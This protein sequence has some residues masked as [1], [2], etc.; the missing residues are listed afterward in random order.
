[1]KIIICSLFIF[2]Y[3]CQPNINEKTSNPNVLNEITVPTKESGEPNL[4]T[5]EKGEIYLS[6]IEYLNDSTDALLFSKLENGNWS[7]PKTITSATNLF[8][9]WADFPSIVSYKNNEHQFAAHWMQMRSKGTYDYDVYISQSNDNGISWQPPFI[10][11]RDSIAAEHGFVTMLPLSNDRIFATWLDGRNTKGDNPTEHSGH[12]HHGAMTLQAATFDIKGNIYEEVEL[13]DR[14]C[15]CC[16]TT[17]AITE[18][19]IIVSYRDRSEKEIRDI[20]IVRQLNGKWTAPSSVFEDNWKI[21]GCPVNGPSIKANGSN[22]A[23]AWFTMEGE[24]GVVKIAFSKDNGKSFQKP[25]RVDD[26]DPLGRVDLI[27]DSKDEIIVSWIEKTE[28]SAELRAAKVNFIG[29]SGSSIILCEI[30]PANTSGFPK[31]ATNNNK[32][33]LAWT[34]VDSLSMVKTASLDL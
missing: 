18:E 30:S 4:F 21:A 33:L 22:V 19:G 14:V 7:N 34:E 5:N 15:D 2:L 12:G 23:L 10:P 27:F 6:W 25:V 8:V 13:D 20:S 29:K 1:M 16:Q 28:N 32:I 31:L 26:G 3:A 11:H 17:A 24:K 9:N